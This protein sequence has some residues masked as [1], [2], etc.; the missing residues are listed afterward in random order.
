[1]KRLAIVC[2]H[3]VQYNVP[4]FQLLEKDPTI[5]IK[6]F[7]TFSQ[8][9]NDFFDKDFG[10]EIKWDVPLLEGYNYEFIENNSKSPGLDHFNGIKCPSLIRTVKSWGASH[11]LLFGW[12]YKAHLKAMRYFKGK[13]PVWFRGD[14]TLLDEKP[15]LKKIVRRV[16]LR[17]VYSH[18]DKAFYVGTNNKQYFKAHGLEDHQLLFA[19]HAI[20]N[21]RFSESSKISYKYEANQWRNNL[22]IEPNEKV[23][24]FCGKLEPKKAP[25]WLLNTFIQIKENPFFKHLKLIYVGNGILEKQLK[26]N[27]NTRKDVFFIPFQNQSTM[28]IIYRLADIFC[29]PSGGPGETWGLVVNEAMASGCPVLASNKVGSAKDLVIEGYTGFIFHYEN[30]FDFVEKLNLLIYS[31]LEKLGANARSKIEEWSF[32]AIKESIMKAF[33]K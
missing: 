29:L 10:R 5:E 17:W 20:D 9:Q 30:S 1:M 25:D 23:L 31:D 4:I 14:S 33:K 19:P 27:A 7:Y 28:P 32:N 3:P 2:T 12:N 22:G 11:I 15:G 16:F 13:I 26:R 6:V 18:I 24:L 8:R 21:F